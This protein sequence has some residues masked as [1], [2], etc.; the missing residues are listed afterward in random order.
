MDQDLQHMSPE[1]LLAEAKK[2]REAIRKH[3]DSQLHELCW[4]HPEM[5]NLLPDKKEVRPSV[6]KRDQ[7]LRGCQI[8]RDSLDK[9]IPEAD[10]AEIEYRPE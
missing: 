10:Q 4:Y 8:Y 3:R 1:E 2:M 5:W 7:F 9:D 6:P